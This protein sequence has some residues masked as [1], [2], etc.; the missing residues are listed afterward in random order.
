MDKNRKLI[1]TL[2]I[3]ISVL[4]ILLAGVII[5][6]TIINEKNA[7]NNQIVNIN[8]DDDEINN[9]N[10][11]TNNI[12]D[13]FKSI[14]VESFNA[15]FEIYKGTEMPAS[16][17]GNLLTAIQTNNET[18]TDEHIIE[19]DN[20]GIT[21]ENQIDTTKKYNVE[22]FY[23]TE[24]YVNKIKITEITAIEPTEGGGE[25]NS[26]SD[27]EK[28]IFNSKFTSYIGEINGIEIEQLMQEIFDNN[29]TNTEHQITYTS[30]NL[31]EISEFLETDRYIITV[32][33]DDA[34]YISNINIDMK[35]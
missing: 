32:Q 2:I 25:Q 10:E 12:A 17:I 33:Y 11:D 28:L 3:V 21:L 6:F 9:Q 29:S 23:D 34:G 16:Q 15:M 13:T 26:V 19:L 24:G 4:V 18:N 22:L 7:N 20:T 8:N 30:N 5:Y 31:Q 14:A 1:I 27:M 35:M